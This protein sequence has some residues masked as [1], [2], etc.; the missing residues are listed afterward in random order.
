MNNFIHSNKRTI[1]MIIAVLI[2]S[3]ASLPACAPYA[4]FK[5]IEPKHYVPCYQP[6]K[7]ITDA[8][9]KVKSDTIKATAAGAFTGAL[10]GLMAR[11]DLKGA[12]IGALIGAAAGAIAGNLISNEVRGKEL[13]ERFALYNTEIDKAQ[14]DLN[15]AS[16]AA[17]KACKCYSDEY[18]K[19]SRA[20]KKVKSPTPEQRAE[21]LEKLEE[22]R[23]GNSVAISILEYYKVTSLDNQKTFDEV[24]AHEETREEDK[25]PKK[26]VR[27]IQNKKK[28]YVQA[29]DKMDK[30]IKLAQQNQSL[31]DSDYDLISKQAKRG[32]PTNKMVL[33]LQKINVKL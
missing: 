7:A 5:T 23:N 33:S 29:T 1:S 30:T 17:D 21:Y 9:E 2:V 6:I 24:V 16:A 18:K 3:L 13:K 10:A 20:Y 19:L 4:G 12:L 11:G 8:A 14:E 32:D 28:K 27:A 31:Y 15:G 26:T 22:I 25:A